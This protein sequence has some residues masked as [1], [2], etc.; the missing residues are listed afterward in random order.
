MS[1]KTFTLEPIQSLP[2]LEPDVRHQR[3][4]VLETV[5]KETV[6][7]LADLEDQINQCDQQI[8]VIGIRKSELEAQITEAKIALSIE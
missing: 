3:I 7:T 4:T 1:D 5:D 8:A 6:F 2:S